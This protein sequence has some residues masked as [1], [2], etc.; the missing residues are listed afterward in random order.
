MVNESAAGRSMRGNRDGRKRKAAETV[1]LVCRRCRSRLAKF[2]DLE[3]EYGGHYS[4]PQARQIPP[5]PRK[6]WT[7][8]CGGNYP[9]TL[10]RMKTEYAAAVQR[11]D[12]V[13][14]LPL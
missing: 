1:R 11:G 5:A 9:V 3:G 14:E 10:E 12:Y 4:L 13:I 7:C 2:R 8:E 6:T